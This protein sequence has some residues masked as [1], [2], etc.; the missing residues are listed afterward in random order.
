M[1]ALLIK[2]TRGLRDVWSIGYD[3]RLVCLQLE[4]TGIIGGNKGEKFFF[5][6]NKDS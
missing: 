6:Y 4:V 2:H 1:L 3:E 5:I